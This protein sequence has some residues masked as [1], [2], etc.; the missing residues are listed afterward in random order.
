MLT[1]GYENRFSGPL[2]ALLSIAFGIFMIATKANAMTLIEQII[3]VAVLAFGV[4]SFLVG[5][6]HKTMQM[7]SMNAIVNIVVALLLFFFA[8]P[9]SAV[10]RYILGAILF[11]FGLYQVMVLFSARNILKGGFMPFVLPVLVMLAGGMFF[12]QELIGNDIMGLIAGIA[13]IL[14]GVSELV[15]SFKMKEVFTHLKEE[16]EKKSASSELTVSDEWT[17]S[18]KDVDYE[19]VEGK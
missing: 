11:F 2:K 10:L 1:F 14:F 16:S 18:A 12:S 3:A 8:G 13:F 7:L 19:K 5:L 17:Q 15:A 6:K 9:I 4:F